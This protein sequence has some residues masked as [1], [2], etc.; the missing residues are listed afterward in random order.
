MF[1]GREIH[2]LETQDRWD[3]DAINS[4]IGVPWR[5]TDGKWTVDRPEVRV[6][7][8]P[9]PPLRFEGARVQSE[10]ITK[11]DINEFGATIACPGCNAIKDNKRAQAHSDRCRMRIEECLRTTPHGAERLDRR[12][13]V[14]NEALA[15]E[16]RRGEQRKKRSDRATA[17]VPETESAAPEPREEPRE[18]EVNPKRRLLLKS[19]SL[20][21]S[22]SGQR[23]EKRSIP[24]DESR[25]QVVKSEPVAV[26]TQEA[27]DGHCEKTM[28]IASVE[29]IELGNIMELSITGQVLRW[30]RQSNLSGGVSLRRADGWSLKYHSHLTVPRHLREKIHPS[31]LVVTNREGE[32]RGMCSAALRELLRVVRD[33]IE[34]RGVAIIAS[35]NESTVWRKT[36]VKTL[37]REKQLKYT[38]VEEMRAVTNDRHIVEQIKSVSTLPV[39]GNLLRSK[40]ENVVM[41]GSEVGKFG[42]IERQRN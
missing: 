31:M 19:A 2:R 11:Q 39:Q 12:N 32:E 7:A 36:S 4:V 13:E 10:R 1:G 5:M 15:G 37:I 28:R 38:D 29:H 3:T 24:D 40:V 6:D 21:A 8:I 26:T 17:A 35:N 25:M 27:V 18:P 20:S 30:A 41:G 42:N 9:I 23:K 22:G 16:V 33:Q 14:I 34:E